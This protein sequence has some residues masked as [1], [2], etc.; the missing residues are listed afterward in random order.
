MTPSLTLPAVE[1][2]FGVK[3]IQAANCRP[4]RNISGAGVF[5]S[6]RVAPIG[7]MPGIL[8]RR[9][10]HSS[11]LCQAM[12][13]ASASA[14]CAC[15]CAYSSAWAA[16]SSR[17]SY[18]RCNPLQPPILCHSPTNDFEGDPYPTHYPDVKVPPYD[19]HEAPPAEPSFLPEAAKY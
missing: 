8:A 14:I 15:S 10:L 13:L 2:S 3:P 5:I 18:G 4:D 11:A 17:A 16:N 9:R 6:S 12:S 19:A 1:W 7:P